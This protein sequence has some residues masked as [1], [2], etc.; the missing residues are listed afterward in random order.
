MRGIKRRSHRI[1]GKIAS[2]LLVVLVWAASSSAWAVSVELNQ[3]VSQ[4]AGGNCATGTFRISTNSSYQGTPLDVLLTVTAA[5]NDH[6]SNCV[7]VSNG[8]LELS[9]EDNDSS[10]NVAWMEFRL[11]LVEQGT[12]NPVTVDRIQ[13]SSFDLDSYQGNGVDSDSDD[14]YL[15]TPTGSA[16]Y[17]SSSTEVAYRSVS[18]SSVG[19]PGLVYNSQ[20]EGKNDGYCNDSAT[21]PDPTC[22]GGAVFTSTSGIDFRI[23]NDDAYGDQGEDYYRLFLVSLKISDLEPIFTDND[24]GD[25]PS[26]YGQ[27]GL[28]RTAYR[29]LGDG[30]IPDEELAYQASTGADADDAA[31]NSLIFDDE[32]AVT[33]GG[34]DLQGQ[35]LTQGQTYDFQVA[36]YNETGASGYL[37]VWID[38]NHDGDFADAGERIVNNQQV[39]AAGA[40]TTPVSVTV[41]ATAGGGTTY[42]RATYSENAISSPDAAGGGTG[43]VEDYAFLLPYL[44]DL[45]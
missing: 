43:E 38:W 23:Q 37:N 21:N 32:G 42:V 3:I 39:T 29:S 14:V 1:F 18:L 31:T 45:S 25:A 20:L 28:E 33:L 24:Y 4:P 27:A 35:T 19:T 13:L 34:S 26:S 11:E 2:L 44:A 22:R 36:T 40:S 17:L 8:I 5:D 10:D 16:V 6:S 9:I 12:S 41:P 15:Y 7:V 30:L